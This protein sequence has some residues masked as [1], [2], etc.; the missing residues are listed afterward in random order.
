MPR[1]S[2]GK[3]FSRA[4]G[5]QHRRRPITSRRKPT[6]ERLEERTL[7]AVDLFDSDNYLWDI[8]NNGSILGGTSVD[9]Y[10]NGMVLV[11]FANQP[12][13]TS[14]DGGREIVTGPQTIGTVSVTRKVYVPADR[15]FARFLEIVTNPSSSYTSY[16]VAIETNLGSDTAT[17]IFRT[18]SGDAIFDLTDNFIITDDVNGSGDPSMLHILSGESGVNPVVAA[19]TGDILKHSYLLSLAPGETKIVMH[20]A[21]QATS[22]SAALLKAAGLMQTDRPTGTD[23]EATKGMTTTELRQVVNFGLVP[24]TP[25]DYDFSQEVD[26]NDHAKWVSHFGG[27]TGQPLRSDGNGDNVVNAADYTVWRDRLGSTGRDVARDALLAGVTQIGLVGSPGRVAV[28]DP[29]GVAFG[30][31]GFSVINDSKG[32]SL[33]AAATVD[34]A[35]IVAFGHDGYTDFANAGNTF[36]TGQLYENSLAWITRTASKSIA[37]VTPHAGTRTWLLARGY[38]NVTLRSDWENALTS[39]AVLVTDLGPGVSTAKQTAVRNFVQRGGGLITGGTGWGYAS[40]GTDLRTMAGNV[41]LR[42]YG[43]GWADDFIDIVNNGYVRGTELGNATKALN[44]AQGIWAGAVAT[45]EQKMEI[46]A[47]VEAAIDVLPLSYSLMQYF[48]EAFT[49]RLTFTRATLAT[50]IS[51][52]LD[53]MVLTYDANK[54][55]ITPV[56][57]VVAHP[58]AATLY[59][60]IS[61]STPRVTSNV[62]INPAQPRWQATGLYAVPGEIVTI[63]VPAALV[64]HGYKVRINTHSDDISRRDEWERL[65]VVHRT[66]GITQTSFQVASAFGGSIF[67][68]LG[69]SPAGGAAV[70]VTIAGAIEQPY[71]VLGT[72]T[73]SQWNTV[74]RGKAAPYAVLVSP[75]KVIV[76][77]K[78]QIESANLT[79]PT[80]L[81]TWWNEAV[82]LEDELAAQTPFRT[83]PELTNVDV[84]ISAGA[85]HAGYPIQAYQRFWTNMA[86]WTN[87]QQN[88]SWGDFHEVGHNHQRDWWTFDGDGEVS[89][90]IFSNYVL[91][92]LTPNTND[93]GWGWSARPVE[94][95]D[96]AISDV[97]PGGTYS[98]KSNRWSFWFQLADGFGWNTYRT[99]FTQYETDKVNNPAL[100]PTTNQQEK[101]QW[102]TRWSNAV[103]YDMKRFM[104]DTWGLEVSTAAQNAVAALPDWMP[105]AHRTADFSLAPNATRTFNL[106]TAGVGMDGVAT[107]VSVGSP[108]IGS[109]TNLGGGSY[110]YNAPASG[111]TNGTFTVTYRS[112]A[113]NTQTFTVKVAVTASAAAPSLVGLASPAG[114]ALA[115]FDE[116]AVD[117]ALESFANTGSAS[118]LLLA[119]DLPIITVADDDEAFNLFEIESSDSVEITLDELILGQELGV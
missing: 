85:A 46:R 47:A 82:R 116:A 73:D 15:A 58:T 89:V 26:G 24:A 117:A 74:L 40:G 8:Q 92:T 94:V 28:F 52:T 81:M 3:L 4:L 21:A 37:I 104:V 48:D 35:R 68:D 39:A 49:P 31:G 30:Q 25:G 54:W 115:R 1:F 17:T 11:G 100:L 71:F 105:L 9:P 45:A 55:L 95:M 63:T 59:G 41:L 10:D 108:T 78:S 61:G 19:L 102:F 110:R 66:F 111:S 75:R 32:Q 72:H 23:N 13:Q 33:V 34:A 84:Q 69:A 79:T 88:G 107:F 90:N 67:F 87:L 99:V 7:L 109:I 18:G 12:T 42:D 62:S 98:A 50:P 6:L 38:T 97:A 56:A 64:G 14:E 76:L 91:E 80:A 27:T 2:L 86:D 112:S 118:L 101:D 51:D 83:S 93:G 77:P 113:N 70:S 29:P 43:L 57:Q 96:H 44:S 53:K 65:P 114:V 119:E 60:A 103:G 36:N 16:T 20:F 22:Q 106:G 5:K